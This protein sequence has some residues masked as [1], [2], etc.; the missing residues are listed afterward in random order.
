MK[1]ASMLGRY[2]A[3]FDCSSD[4]KSDPHPATVVAGYV[5][6]VEQWA[7]WE[8]DWR[9]VLAAFDV[10]YF[11][12]R[13]FNG[14]GGPFSSPKWRSS[15]YRAEF[16][17]RLANVTTQWTLGSFAGRMEQRIYEDANQLC[18]VERF[19]N[20]YAACGRD[21]AVR[22][23]NFVRNELGSNFPID[24]VF[25][26][27]DQGVGMLNS[28]MEQSELP[29]PVF[30]RPRFAKNAQ[31]DVND[32]PAISLQAADLLAWEVRRAVKDTANQKRLRKSMKSLQSARNLS[33][34]D[35]GYEEIATLIHSLYIPRREKTAV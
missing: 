15:L 23:R 12:M 30:K 9:L 26:R 20:P 19:L 6:T 11:H 16:V 22:V 31:L 4:G 28:L 34:K 3:C 13:E 18:E 8:Y 7:S 1:A 35:C 21:C 10:P 27:G 33:W 2:E 17:S 5:A 24:F 29:H 25:E 32:P 14:F